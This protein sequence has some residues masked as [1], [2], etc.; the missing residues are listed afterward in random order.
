MAVGTISSGQNAAYSF[1]TINFPDGMPRIPEQ[2]MDNLATRGLDG[3][4]YAYEGLQ[5]RP[6]T[7]SG[8]F[9]FATLAEAK[10]A[11]TT[12][13][14]F[15]NRICSFT[16]TA[17]ATSISYKGNLMCLDTRA[18]AAAALGGGSNSVSGQQ[19]IVRAM[20]VLQPIS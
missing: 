4:L 1:A 6:F 10:A 17:F 11:E 18:R 5:Y 19:A 7:V 2:N 9:S 15:R 3:V 8:I 12:M 20:F 13:L 16:T 14:A